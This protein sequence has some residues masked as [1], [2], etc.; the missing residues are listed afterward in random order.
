MPLRPPLTMSDI[1]QRIHNALSIL[2]AP[3]SRE[4]HQV[5]RTVGL[6]QETLRAAEQALREMEGELEIVSAPDLQAAKEVARLRRELEKAHEQGVRL[7]R[8]LRAAREELDI[9]QRVHA[10]ER[11]KLADLEQRAKKFDSVLLQ[12]DQAFARY[13]DQE[14]GPAG[15]KQPKRRE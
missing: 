11:K 15:S 8:E 5:P 13:M 3:K 2:A 9:E 12:D 10:D 4:P 6:A 1:H 14:L 7:E